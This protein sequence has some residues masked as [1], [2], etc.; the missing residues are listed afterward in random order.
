MHILAGEVEVYV[1]QLFV[2][3]IAA[4]L[5]FDGIRGVHYFPKDSGAFIYS[6]LVLSVVN[7]LPGIPTLNIIL[8]NEP[9]L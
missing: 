1:L 2:Y 5:F 9:C 6:F 8:N 4:R 7:L 3:N